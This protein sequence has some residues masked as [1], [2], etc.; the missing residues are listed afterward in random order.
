M[1]DMKREAPT[2]PFELHL[3]L[4][5][6]TCPL[7]NHRKVRCFLLDAVV[8]SGGMDRSGVG[9]Q[10][11]DCKLA[12]LHPTFGAQISAKPSCRTHRMRLGQFSLPDRGWKTP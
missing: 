3:G 11:V 9:R 1:E 6:E 4:R 8:P 10:E 5:S 7:G 2:V 12:A